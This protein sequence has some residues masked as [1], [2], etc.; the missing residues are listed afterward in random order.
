MLYKKTSENYPQYLFEHAS[1]KYIETNI[2]NDT[3]YNI[4]LA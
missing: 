2:S 3:I 1:F 4:S